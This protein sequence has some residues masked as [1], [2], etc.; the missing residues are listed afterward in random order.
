MKAGKGVYVNVSR[1]RE[2]Y[3]LTV[4]PAKIL[5]PEKDRFTTSMRGWMRPNTS[6]ARFLEA[7][8]ENG[9]THHSIFVY[10]ATAQ[11]M[12]YFGRLLQ[13]KTTV[14]DEK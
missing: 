3:K 4:A 14:I 5:E 13:M 1:A 8:S 6:T 12:E 2:D 7:L 11:E 9:A 10:G